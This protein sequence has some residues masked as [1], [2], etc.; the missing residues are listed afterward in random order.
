MRADGFKDLQDKHDTIVDH[1]KKGL[2]VVPDRKLFDFYECFYG[3]VSRLNNYL[4][5]LG[6]ES[7]L[8]SGGY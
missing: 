8:I 4:N 5:H 7:Y 6:I 1:I 3:C 2:S